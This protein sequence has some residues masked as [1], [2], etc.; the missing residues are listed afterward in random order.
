MSDD[1]NRLAESERLHARVRDFAEQ[2]LGASGSSESFE[3]LAAD[4][5]RFQGSAF[6][7]N[8]VR[9]LALPPTVVDAFR[10]ADVF[11]FPKAEARETFLTSGTTAS[12]SGK[13]HFRTT[14][15][16]QRVAQLWGERALLRVGAAPTRVLALMSPPQVPRRS[17]LG[18]MAEH[19][20][21]IFPGSGRTEQDHAAR[22]LLRS[23]GVDLE[24]LRKQVELALRA[25]ETV[26]LLAT[27]FALVML[28]D[29]LAGEELRLPAGS[30]V[31]PTGGYKG[32]TR[33]VA[34]EEL[35]RALLATFGEVAFVS[36]YG[37]TELS[38]QLYEGT[39]PGGA[40][41]AEP[42]VYLAPP[43]LRVLAL[44]PV[45]FEPLP[46]GEQGI[47]AFIDLANVDSRLFVVT[48]DLIRVSSAG[49]RLFGRRPR[50]P[51]R[52]CSLAVEALYEG[53]ERA[54][55]SE[56]EIARDATA[57]GSAASEP[58]T[59]AVVSVR[60]DVAACSRVQRL[61]EVAATI[62]DPNTEL[63]QRA[64]QRWAA[65]L[66]LS[67]QAI[68][69]GLSCLESAVGPEQIAAFCARA[70]R[71]PRVW[72][73]LSANVFVAPLRAIAWA[74]AASER[75]S[76]RASRRDPVL[77]EQ[78]HEAVPDLFDLVSEITPRAGEQVHAYGS[79]ETMSTLLA[80]LPAGVEL[81]AH[82][83]GMGI[84]LVLNADSPALEEAARGFARDAVL[85]EQRGC[86]SPRVIGLHASVQSESF[87]RALVDALSRWGEQVPQPELG[88][89][90]R[91]DR[92]WY[93][94]LARNAG[95]LHDL[96]PAGSVLFQRTRTEPLVAPPGRHL[97][98]FSDADPL[99]RLGAF[100][101]LTTT[102]GVAASPDELLRL[103]PV[104][105]GVR[106][107]AP[108]RMQQPRFDGPVDL[109]RSN[110]PANS[111]C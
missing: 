100:E 47:A 68:E 88:V 24:A 105:A 17:S 86:L 59:R 10:A 1:V 93:V 7:V 35:K 85:F 45:T 25:G 26:H 23:D 48:Q 80:T 56:V 38:S 12:Q 110:D 87:V 71:A 109:R 32:R 33:E 55:S 77:A 84:G 73:I 64:R 104:H 97:V 83:S 51:L 67:L 102:L 54:P 94:N 2:S 89:E 57:R 92:N 11:C 6:G 43:W 52:G 42:G 4:I 37:M 39:L 31:M 30:V 76:V 46:M 65:S 99:A 40:L 78:L 16:Y 81:W 107:T 3:A 69:L 91:A 98:V 70:P 49:V 62:K 34:A 96:G 14:E 13:H 29:A 53:R 74:V 21:R 95:D 50:A 82:G 108:G 22:W 9:A 44:D 8:P 18:F 111:A 103:Q 58:S 28:L 75:V 36:E 19:F 41:R 66:G 27:S 63:G 20:M 72:T 90:E 60:D 61:L 79:D 101:S 15:T 5:A 106:V